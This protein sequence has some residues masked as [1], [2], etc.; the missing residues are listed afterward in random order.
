MLTRSTS[1]VSSTPTILRNHWYNCGVSDSTLVTRSSTSSSEPNNMIVEKRD[2]TQE[3]QVLIGMVVNDSVLAKISPKWTKEGLF[4]SPWSNLIGK[5]CV[6]FHRKY[7]KAPGRSLEGIYTAW[8]EGGTD[9]DTAKIVEKFLSGLSSEYAD[10]KESIN[11][12]FIVDVAGKHFH[13]VRLKRLSEIIQADIDI[14]DL[15]KAQK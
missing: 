8:S 2:S 12:D 5:W 10:L 6:E 13:R 9:P 14:G 1:S 4:N 15:E 7:D 3:R 11:P